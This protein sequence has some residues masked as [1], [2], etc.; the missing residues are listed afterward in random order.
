MCTPLAPQS[1]YRPVLTHEQGY[2]EFDT[3]LVA[4][5]VLGQPNPYRPRPESLVGN[6]YSPTVGCLERTTADD[7]AYVEREVSPTEG[8]NVDHGDDPHDIPQPESEDIAQP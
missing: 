8:D 3:P 6:P 4:A 2:S 7:D 1:G 5:I